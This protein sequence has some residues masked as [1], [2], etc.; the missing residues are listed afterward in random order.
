MWISSK[1]GRYCLMSPAMSSWPVCLSGAAPLRPAGFWCFIWKGWVPRCWCWCQR[2]HAG[3]HGGRVRRGGRGRRPGGTAARS[4]LSPAVCP[5]GRC[6]PGTVAQHLPSAD[7]MTPAR[8]SCNRKSPRRAKE[9]HLCPA[10]ALFWDNYRRI[11]RPS[12]ASTVRVSPGTW[13]PAMIS[14]AIMVSTLAWIYRLR[15]RAP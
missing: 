11:R 3:Y 15:G 7:S 6:I 14:L 10:G 2:R 5:A 8:R 12:C 13:E 9:L 1:P 4:R